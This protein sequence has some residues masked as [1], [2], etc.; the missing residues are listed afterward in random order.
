MCGYE[1]SC[2]E[3]LVK[4]ISH[5]GVKIVGVGKLELEDVMSK[6]MD[7]LEKKIK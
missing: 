2:I 5:G 6:F 4:E 3:Y 1:Q 7:R